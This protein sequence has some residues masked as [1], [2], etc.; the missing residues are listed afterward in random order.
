M[1]FDQYSNSKFET[2]K[3]S[4]KDRQVKDSVYQAKNLIK[5]GKH[6]QKRSLTIQVNSKPKG[7]SLKDKY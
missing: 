2:S 7:K 1:S 3:I 4:V 5:L 6:A